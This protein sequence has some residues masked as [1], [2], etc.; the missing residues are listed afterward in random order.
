MIWKKELLDDFKKG[1]I[2]KANSDSPKHT[3]NSD[4]PKHTLNSPKP[5]R[6]GRSLLEFDPLRYL[7]V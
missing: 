7:L 5:D 6:W 2:N 3:L 4:S 1:V